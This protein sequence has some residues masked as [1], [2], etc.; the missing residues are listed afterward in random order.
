VAQRHAPIQHD[1]SLGQGLL[2]PPQWSELPEVSTQLL[3][4]KVSVPAQLA[5]HRLC[6]Q[7]RPAAHAVPHAPQLRPSD[8][9]STQ[10]PLQLD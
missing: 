4:H 3:P 9:G 8:L 6:E 2:Q 1:W 5:E 7:T 10:T